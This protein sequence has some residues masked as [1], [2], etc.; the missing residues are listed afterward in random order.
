MQLHQQLVTCPA[1][2]Y[3]Y[4]CLLTSS[5]NT[6]AAGEPP[7]PEQG[8]EQGSQQR[9]GRIP[10]S[11]NQPPSRPLGCS[12]ISCP[13]NFPTLLFQSCH[14]PVGAHTPSNFHQPTAFLIFFPFTLQVIIY[15]IS[16]CCSAPRAPSWMHPDFNTTSVS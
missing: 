2:P 9:P 3:G 14:L 8:G 11:V 7:T 4:L 5:E 16:C 10:N 15:S 13:R 1:L 6:R 12:F